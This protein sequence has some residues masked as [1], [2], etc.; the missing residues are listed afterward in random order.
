MLNS[1][2]EKITKTEI[3]EQE[4]KAHQVQQELHDGRRELTQNFRSVPGVL[5][6]VNHMFGRLFDDAEPGT[7]AA[8]VP[9][10][11][12]RSALPT[13]APAVATFGGPADVQLVAEV[14]AVEAVAVA[15]L[16]RRIKDEQWVILDPVTE[17]VRPARFD[18]VEE[19]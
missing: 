18:D 1:M 6:W 7:Q 9:L 8:H 2:I 17:E 12:Q 14:R 16:V 10:I 5:D 15:E 3:I 11:A 4:H 19:D 13:P